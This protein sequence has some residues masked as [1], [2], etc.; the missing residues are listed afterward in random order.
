M[1]FVAKDFDG[2][3]DLINRNHGA[4]V[5]TFKVIDNNF[6][7]A[8]KTLTRLS[9]ITRRNGFV[10]LVGVGLG[11]VASVKISKLE[12]KVNMLQREVNELK[13][14]DRV[15]GEESNSERSL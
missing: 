7:G 5:E 4:Y 8:Y 10:A 14:K 1:E 15:Y 2:L 13:I 9:K 6:D 11:F 3:L 12:T